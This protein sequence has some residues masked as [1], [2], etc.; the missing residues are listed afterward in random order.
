MMTTLPTSKLFG[1]G[2][3]PFQNRNM[4]VVF[5]LVGLELLTKS[6]YFFPETQME[7]RHCCFS[8]TWLFYRP[9]KSKQVTVGLRASIS[10]SAKHD[11]CMV[12]DTNLPNL[13]LRR[14]ATERA[15]V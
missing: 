7:T 11:S 1:V 14:V 13:M 5:W 2:T 8:E 10:S 9:V 4:C 3:T 15:G 6:S 12:R